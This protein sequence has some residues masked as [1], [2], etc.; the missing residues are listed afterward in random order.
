[1]PDATVAAITGGANILGGILGGN[2][3]KSAARTSANAQ[4]EAARIG[5]QAG[6]FRPVGISTRF[7]QSQFVTEVDPSTGLP[8]LKEAGYTLSPEVAALQEQLLGLAP[9]ALTRAAGAYERAAPVEQAAQGLFGLGAQYLGESPEAVRQR[10]MSQQQALLEPTRQ[11]EEQRLAQSVFGRGRAGLNIGGGGQPELAALAGARRMQDLQLAAAADQ[12]A[13]QQIQFGQGLFGQGMNLLSAV[14]AYQ[15]AALSPFSAYLSGAQNIEQL[16]QEPLRLGAE[17]GGRA[18]T[19]GQA[20][21][22]LLA[23]AGQNAANLQAQAGM[24]GPTI[25]A[26]MF[27]SALSNPYFMNSIVGQPSIAAPIPA[28][29]MQGSFQPNYFPTTG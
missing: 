21:G 12:A 29:A 25:T 7:G 27:N 6:A 19:A 1:M 23:Q 26:G 8:V 14:P 13:Q 11:A 17:L 3:A 22:A 18:S 9:G 5:A 4:L 16:G 20:G 2:A 24:V 28:N 10:Y 15:T